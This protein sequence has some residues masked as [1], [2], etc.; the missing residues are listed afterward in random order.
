MADVFPG[1]KLVQLFEWGYPQGVT[2]AIPSASQ[3]F[4]V[5]HI[6]GNSR[7]PTA[8]GETSWRLNDPDNQN[9]A[10]FFVNRDGSIV[11]A[12]GNPL[13]MAPWSNGDTNQPDM[14][15]ARIAACIKAGVN[16]NMRTIVSIECV[17]YEPGYSIT[18]AQK[19]A[20]AAIIAYYHKQAGVPVNRETVIG[21]Y[22]INSVNRPNC[23]GKDKSILD[24]IVAYA[25]EEDPQVIQE[26]EEKLAL[27][28]GRWQS[29]KALRIEAEA[30][31]AEALAALEPLQAQLEDVGGDLVEARRLAKQLRARLGTVKDIVAEMAIEVENT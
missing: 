2:R 18:T 19:K 27:Y 30:K 17:G 20:C 1:A 25:T 26:L 29:N 22:Q 3:A 4:S 7:L 23:P 24:E 12:L 10:T 9:S 31:L 16:P 28:Y 13:R 15:N 11:Q 6:T 21:H 5:V 8:E 14:T